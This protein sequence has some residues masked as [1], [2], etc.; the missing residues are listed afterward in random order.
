MANG[1]GNNRN[2]NHS[3]T[4]KEGRNKSNNAAASTSPSSC[5]SVDGV[6]LKHLDDDEHDSD[7]SRSLFNYRPTESEDD[8]QSHEPVLIFHDM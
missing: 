7:S 3:V 6:D 4:T 8:D 5:S 1:S 2:E